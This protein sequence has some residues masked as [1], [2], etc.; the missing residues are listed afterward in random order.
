MIANPLSRCVFGVCQAE[1][2][3]LI[4][5]L[6]RSVPAR[7][8]FSE[9]T[10]SSY[11]QLISTEMEEHVRAITQLRCQKYRTTFSL[12]TKFFGTT[13]LFILHKLFSV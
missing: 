6:D 4:I 5:I 11:C 10:C 2:F 12:Q 9:R 8:F 13:K 7:K 1:F 3:V